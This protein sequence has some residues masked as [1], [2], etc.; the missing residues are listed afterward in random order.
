MTSSTNARTEASTTPSHGADALGQPSVQSPGARMGQTWTMREAADVCGVSLDTIKRRRR[1]GL[2][3][4]VAKVDGA[5]RI[6]SAELAKVAAD[7]GWS[8][9]LP[10]ALPG[11]EHDAGGVQVEAAAPDVHGAV[12]VAELEARLVHV[13]ELHGAELAAKDEG[14]AG[15]LD[16]VQTDL[17]RVTADRDRQR[18]DVDHLRAE[19]DRVK[20]EKVELEKTAAVA[21]ALAAERAEM[22]AKVELQAEDAVV[23]ADGVAAERDRAVSLLG[24]MG[25]NKYRKALKLREGTG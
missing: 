22:L 2:F 9:V 18:S 13:H 19:L 5:W 20:A 25:R 15:E 12:R 3:P 10:D 16:R 11:A 24:W 23:R 4:G 6:P 17:D 21:E 7:E 1:D 14:H 8:I